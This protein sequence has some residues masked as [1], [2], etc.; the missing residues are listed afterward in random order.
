MEPFSR[1]WADGYSYYDEKTDKTYLLADTVID[2]IK[3]A[4]NEVLEDKWQLLNL[5]KNDTDNNVIDVVVFLLTEK[6]MLRMSVLTIMKKYGK[7]PLFVQ[8]V[9]ISKKQNLYGIQ[10]ILMSVK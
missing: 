1:V 5:V 10:T 7:I 3:N 9:F 6:R 8:S 4:F 2:I